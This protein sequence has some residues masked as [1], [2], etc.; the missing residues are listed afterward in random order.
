MLIFG[1]EYG[2]IVI[3]D[4]DFHSTDR[5]YKLFNG[6]V[7]GLSYLF[8]KTNN[9]RQFIIALGD[10]ARPVE[11][12]DGTVANPTPIYVVKVFN[13]SDM[14][15]PL[16]K[17]NATITDAYVTAFA[18]HHDGTEI[19]VGYSN[20]RVLLYTGFFLTENSQQRP[21]TTPQVILPTHFAP[22]SAAYFCEIGSGYG[23][24]RK[25]KLFVV[26]ETKETVGE[27]ENKQPAIDT[28]IEQEDIQ[29]AGII[30]F[31]TSISVNTGKG[32]VIYAPREDPKALDAKGATSLCAS[33]MKNT[34]ELVIARD[35]AIY[36]YTIE[37]RGGALAIFGDKQSIVTVG[38]YTLV[39][40]VDDKVTPI[41]DLN[42]T[43][44]AQSN[45]SNKSIVTIYDLKNKFVCG[46]TKKYYLPNNEKILFNF[47]DNGGIAYLITSNYNLIRFREKDVHRKLDVLLTQVKPPMFPL[48]ITLAGEE[49]LESQEIMKLYKMYGDHLYQK[50]EF[51]SAIMQYCYTIGYVPP[52][53]VIV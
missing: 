51:D 9:N 4:R 23:E 8:D 16:Y 47:S 37:D 2:N 27:E 13:T 12:L 6:S 17:L 10:D 35:E 1:D 28:L 43:T 30:V 19:A 40:S 53:Y 33:F 18:V 14:N 11:T 39:V 25:I 38:R 36:T 21:N 20:G 52:S 41:N 49:Q 7:I 26:F 22:V 29:H 44:T 3:S 42:P 31:D 50:H 32:T 48:A 46:T 15:R 45:K 5:R 34:S 24:D